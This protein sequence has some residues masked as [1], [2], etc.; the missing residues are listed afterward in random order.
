MTSHDFGLVLIGITLL[1]AAIVFLM[2]MVNLFIIRFIEIGNY[3]PAQLAALAISGGW[4]GILYPKSMDPLRQKAMNRRVN[5]LGMC[6]PLAMIF[7]FV[8]FMLMHVQ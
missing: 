1:F 3:S 6:L 7:G 4:L 8:G 5:I 2:I